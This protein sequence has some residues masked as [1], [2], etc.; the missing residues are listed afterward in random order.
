MATTRQR[1]R[2]G[3]ARIASGS[4]A[5]GFTGAALSISLALL[6][7]EGRVVPPARGCGRV[8]P[9]R[10]LGRRSAQGL[11]SGAAIRPD[12]AQAVEVLWLGI[13]GAAMAPLY[14]L[15]NSADRWIIGAWVGQDSVGVYSFAAGMGRD[16]ESS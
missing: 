9:R 15:M 11:R 10:H 13:A 16:G 4:V 5:M 3:Y 12:P 14:W 2:E 1:L 7:E 8:V 6:L